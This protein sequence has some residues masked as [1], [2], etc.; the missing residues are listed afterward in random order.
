[1]SWQRS[2]ALALSAVLVVA[3]AIVA[4]RYVTRPK[5]SN[6]DLLTPSDIDFIQ[7]DLNASLAQRQV[8]IDF[9]NPYIAD[10]TRP[11]SDQPIIQCSTQTYF[12][13]SIDRKT[14]R[15]MT[16]LTEPGNRSLACWTLN[17]TTASG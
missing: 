8:L 6:A 5:I 3:L 16:P 11:G 2:V 14:V 7:R 12:D 15:A 9:R 13:A 17:S 4:Y 1:V 10:V